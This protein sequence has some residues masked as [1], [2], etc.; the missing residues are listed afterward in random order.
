MSRS[1]R[2]CGHSNTQLEKLENSVHVQRW[3]C[4]R[5]FKF[6]STLWPPR[7]LTYMQLPPVRSS[8]AWRRGGR[9]ALPQDSGLFS[10]PNSA[11]NPYLFS[12]KLGEDHKC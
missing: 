12:P 2:L 6:L 5:A 3:R 7:T 8:D 4:A 1:P 11:H 9:C 10:N